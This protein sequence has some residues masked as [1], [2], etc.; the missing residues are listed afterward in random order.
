MMTLPP[1]DSPANTSSQCSL[2]LPSMATEKLLPTTSGGP[3]PVAWSLPIRTLDPTGSDTCMTRSF[4]AS[5][6][7]MSAGASAKVLEP[8]RTPR[9]RRTGRNEN[10]SRQFPS[11]VRYVLSDMSVLLRPQ[12]IS[13]W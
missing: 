2:L 9:R 7:L 13:P 1:A 4:S 10:A 11:N 6:T 3:N 12:H 5:G 8:R